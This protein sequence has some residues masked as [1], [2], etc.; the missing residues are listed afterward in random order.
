[1]IESSLKP[2]GVH[3]TDD[4]IECAI[5]LLIHGGDKVSDRMKQIF[6]KLLAFVLKDDETDFGFHFLL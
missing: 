6:H 4:C 5:M 2:E 1:M 3:I